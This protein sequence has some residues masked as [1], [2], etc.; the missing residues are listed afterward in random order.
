MRTCL[1]M[2][3]LLVLPAVVEGQ[4]SSDIFVAD[5]VL[6]EGRHVV[7]EAANVTAREGYDNQPWFVP[8]GSGF[9][10]VSERGGQTDVYRYDLGSG[11]STQVTRTP[12]NEYSPTLQGDGSRMLVVRWPT[13][14]TTGALWWYTASGEPVA[15]ATGS[16][17]RVGYYALADDHTLAL[18]IN[19]SIQSFLLSDTRTGDTIRVGSDLGGSGPR[20]IP[21]ERAVSYLKRGA[22]DERWLARLEIATLAT[23]PLVRM[24]DG[25]TNYTWTDAGTVLA[26][27]GSTIYEWRPGGDWVAVAAFDASVVGTITRI[28]ISAAGDRVAFVGVT[29]GTEAP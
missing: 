8:D 10:Y 23:T 22:D 1:A 14:M 24:L 15:E 18:F 21:G 13:D 7:G 2:A 5:L 29:G 11:R 27:R 12:Y 19:D 3:A 6:V 9:L 20:R 25:V 26:A 4:A 17:E 16:V 28:A